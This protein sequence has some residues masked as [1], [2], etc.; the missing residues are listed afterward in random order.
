MS[1][2]WYNLVV[3]WITWSNKGMHRPMCNSSRLFKRVSSSISTTRSSWQG[4]GSG[5][6]L[7]LQKKW[8]LG[9]FRFDSRLMGGSRL[10][11]LCTTRLGYQL[12][13]S[14]SASQLQL[15]VIRSHEFHLGE[16]MVRSV[17]DQCKVKTRIWFFWVFWSL[18]ICISSSSSRARSKLPVKFWF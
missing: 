11:V 9:Q 15:A 6:G 14:W 1:R 4:S 16:G 8:K 17:P 10:V 12:T 2:R 3:G 5:S 18:E 13:S 7:F